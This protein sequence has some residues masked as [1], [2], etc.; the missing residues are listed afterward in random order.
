[1]WG[2]AYTGG[3][4]G[5]EP[6]CC[7]GGD[8]GVDQGTSVRGDRVRHGRHVRDGERR[9]RGGVVDVVHRATRGHVVVVVLVVV[10]VVVELAVVVGGIWVV[11]NEGR[12]RGYRGGGGGAGS[13]AAG[14]TAVRRDGACERVRAGVVVR[15]RIWRSTDCTHKHRNNWEGKKKMSFVK[16][17]LANKNNGF[18]QLIFYYWMQDLYCENCS[19]PPKSMHA[20]IEK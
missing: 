16:T 3:G 13:D 7:G 6:R 9:E 10:V 8:T 18:Q 14:W 17:M 19:P 20:L 15:W 2:G 12:G 11:G 4:R 5:V 1:M